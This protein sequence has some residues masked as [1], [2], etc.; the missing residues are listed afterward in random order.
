MIGRFCALIAAWFAVSA[1]AVPA[2]DKK[3]GALAQQAARAERWF[4]LDRM[5]FV[6]TQAYHTYLARTGQSRPR[7][8]GGW[9]TSGDIE[10]GFK[11]GFVT[12]DGADSIDGWIELSVVFA[13]DARPDLCA[14]NNSSEACHGIHIDD[15]P[16]ELSEHER[17]E[18]KLRQHLST[19]KISRCGTSP[20]NVLIDREEQQWLVYAMSTSGTPGTYVRYGHSLLRFDRSSMEMLERRKLFK[21]CEFHVQGFVESKLQLKF[22][23]FGDI[24]EGVLFRVLSENLEIVVAASKKRAHTIKSSGLDLDF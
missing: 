19:V 3:S 24:D 4:R 12:L 20:I 17:A 8:P 11:F 15:V 18:L 1:L 23:R 16:R 10:Q 7:Y 14:L 22:K 6:A 2:A 21:E 9:V 13:A 5:A